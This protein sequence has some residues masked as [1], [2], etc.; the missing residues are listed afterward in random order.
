M[1]NDASEYIE[2]LITPDMRNRA[3][4]VSDSIPPSNRT[5]MSKREWIDGFIAEEMF[6]E[7]IKKGLLYLPFNIAHSSGDTLYHCDFLIDSSIRL[8][9]KNKGCKYKP[10]IEFEAS[11]S[12]YSYNY[13][14]MDI[15]LFART[16]RN[17]DIGWLVGWI[18]KEEFGRKSSLLS[19]GT[20]DKTNNLTAR[21]DT[22]NLKYRDCHPLSSLKQYMDTLLRKENQ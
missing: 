14:K 11:V 5:Y 3:K 9:V 7:A 20:T 18:T 21:T 8:E 17:K 4:K 1:I 22:F 16:N 19:K 10:S 6:K 15:Y 12:K 13:Q 2:L